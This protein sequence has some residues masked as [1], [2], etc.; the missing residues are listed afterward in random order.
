MNRQIRADLFRRTRGSKLDIFYKVCGGTFI[1]TQVREGR[2]PRSIV[3]SW[4]P[5]E[6]EF[7]RTRAEYLLY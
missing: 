1:Q 5:N 7:R 4:Q 6:E 3:A 2:S